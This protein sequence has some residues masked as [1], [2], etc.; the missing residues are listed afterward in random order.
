[1]KVKIE[2]E[3][4]TFVR[5]WLVVI[6][7]ILAALAIYS[8]RTALIIIGAALF[9]AIALSPSV[10]WLAKML[11]SKSRLLGTAIAY[12]VVVIFLSLVAFLVVPPIVNQTVK[13]AQTVPHLVDTATKQYAGVNSLINQYNLQ[14]EFNKAVTSIKDS[15]SQFA[16]SIGSIVINGIGS[17][18]F[19][20]TAGLLILV[21]AFLMLVE[22]PTWLDRLRSVYRDKELMEYHTNLLNRMYNVVTA[23]ITGQLS[24]SS[25]AGVVA[26]VLVFILSLVFNI[27]LN[28]AIPAATIMFVLSL[29]PMFGELTGA[30]IVFAILALNNFTAAIVF[31]VFFILYSQF[32]GN[33]IVP[34]IQSKKIN[35]SA[36]AVLLAITIGIYL[37]GIV[38]AIISIPIAGCLRVLI[39]DFVAR[40]KKRK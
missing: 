33:F 26:G 13:F 20:V 32:E 24:V 30:T 16:S 29:I 17:V 18:F 10:N 3:T 31:L 7:F 25:I 38:G 12:V 11:R 14:P 4:Q 19:T 15:T 35:L 1:M 37:F 36:L 21:L 40:S 39:E 8:A 9:V 28:L 23:Y 2:I 22:G 5:F 34:K 6:G 27:P